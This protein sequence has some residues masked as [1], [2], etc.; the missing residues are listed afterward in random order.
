[1]TVEQFMQKAESY[2]G[3]GYT[4]EQ[5]V[6]VTKWT[7]KRSPEQ[8][9]KLYRFIVKTWD[10][11]YKTPPTVKHLSD[12]IEELDPYGQ[13]YEKQTDGTYLYTGEL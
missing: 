5:I 3:G 11:R 6:E 4:E 12:Y 13:N 7:R 10:T 1:M 8:L 2:S 9:D